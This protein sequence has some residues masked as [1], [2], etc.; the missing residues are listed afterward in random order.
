MTEWI[1]GRTAWL[2]DGKAAGYVRSDVLCATHD[3]DPLTPAEEEAF[4]DGCDDPCIPVIRLADGP[5]EE[6]VPRFRGGAR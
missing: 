6:Y 2:A 5:G 1:D 3:G 4:A